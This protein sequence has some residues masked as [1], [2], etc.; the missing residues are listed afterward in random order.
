MA[1]ERGSQAKA[2]R[3]KKPREE[4]ESYRWPERRIIARK[5]LVRVNRVTVIQD[6]EGDIYES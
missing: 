6:S 5:A 4:K 3:K 2:K 1:R